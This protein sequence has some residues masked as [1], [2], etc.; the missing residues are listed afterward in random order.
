MR[1]IFSTYPDPLSAHCYNM[2]SQIATIF[3]REKVFYV[4]RLAGCQ[5]NFWENVLASGI[6]PWSIQSWSSSK[7]FWETVLASGTQPW[8][9]Q[10]WSS[11]KDF[12]ETVLASGTQPWSIQSWSRSKDFWENVLA[13]GTK[14]WSIRSWSSSKDFWEVV[15]ASGTD[16]V[17][18]RGALRFFFFSVYNLSCVLYDNFL[19]RI[20]H[21]SSAV[22][23]HNLYWWM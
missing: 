18:L 2:N 1:Q 22:H 12:W 14:P 4:S 11:S 5:L 8:S 7:D 19:S 23:R 10:S 13:S 9:V 6:Q 3:W 16:T 17:S 21:N 20:V 15:L